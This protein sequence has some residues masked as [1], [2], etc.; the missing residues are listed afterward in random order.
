MFRSFFRPALLLAFAVLSFSAPPAGA[1]DALTPGQKDAVERVV[2]DYIL[3]HPDVV[4]EAIRAAQTKAREKKEENAKQ[5]ITERRGELLSD[6]S[7][8]VAGNPQG[9]VTIVEFFDYRCPYC[10]QVEPALEALLKEDGRIRLVYKEFPILGPESM[11]A[12]RVSLAALQQ[13]PQK[14]AR[15]HAALM[16]AKG[17]LGQDSILKAAEAAGLDVARIKTDMNGPEVDALIK[18]NYDLAE[19]L[20]IR[21]TPAFIVGNEMTPGAVDL[22]MFK[23]MVA[24]ARKA[25]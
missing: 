6:A 3:A 8:P 2:H 22:P 5:A 14:Y 11:I 16:S 9:D 23:K 12:S 10:K 13:S 18:R 1:A 25:E 19:T 4:V 15:L 21:G 17:E 20:N 7:A 24:D